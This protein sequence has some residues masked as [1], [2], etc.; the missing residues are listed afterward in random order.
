MPADEHPLQPDKFIKKEVEDLQH[1]NE[2]QPED[3]NKGKEEKQEN[4][5]E[6]EK[7]PW[8]TIKE[9][10]HKHSEE[11]VG[12][13]ESIELVDNPSDSNK[14]NSNENVDIHKEVKAGQGKSRLGELETTPQTELQKTLS[15]TKSEY[16]KQMEILL[17]MMPKLW[18]EDKKVDV[19]KIVIQC[20]KLLNNIESAQFYPEKFIA[21]SDILESFGNLVFKRIKW[22]AF[23]QGA[24]AQAEVRDSE[25]RPEL[26]PEAAKEICNNWFLKTA[27]IREIVP[28][29]YIFHKFH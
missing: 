23:K 27:I 13:D 26:V 2:D 15:I 6:V 18:S 20:A 4:E 22:L 10:I 14:I 12:A 19:L 17:K 5:E 29:W 9:E 8:E 24:N 16:K 1:P 21:I 28:R 11:H 3:A 7:D 25:I